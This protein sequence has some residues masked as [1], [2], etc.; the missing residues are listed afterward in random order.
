MP[1]G[2]ALPP[3]RRPAPRAA[4]LV[5]VALLAVSL[6]LVHVMAR[7]ALWSPYYKI[8]VGQTGADTVVEVNNIF[9][10]SM[11][12]VAQKEYF[13]QWPYTVFGN[14]FKNVLILGAGSGTDVAAALMHGAE[15]VDAVE[16]DPTILRLG[17]QLHPDH[18]FDDPR[19]T[20]I[21]DDA[22]H[23]LRD[24]EQEIRPGG[25]RADRFADAAVELLGRPARELHVHRP[26]RSGPSA[27]A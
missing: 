9:H 15:H 19:V 11:A 24:H 3:A 12:P 2:I 4:V 21:N 13:Y 14:S 5:D 1:A 18:P 25:V 16:I 26:S 10:Q 17:R 27:I 7:G 8:T 23:F 20:V 22:R 6:V